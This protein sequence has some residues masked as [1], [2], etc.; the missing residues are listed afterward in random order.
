MS[1]PQQFF[2]RLQNGIVGGFAPPTPNEV[3]TLTRSS[4]DPSNVLV[5][6]LSRPSGQPDLVDHGPKSLSVSE[7]SAL[8]AD[9]PKNVDSRIAELEE[10]LKNLPT[11]S[12]P[13][14]EDI[15]GLNIGIMYGSDR[16][17]WANGGPQGC[18]GGKS[19]VQATAQ[20]KKQ[21]ERAVEI[22]KGLSGGN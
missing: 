10:I 5:Q 6:A 20:E 3:V 18:G 9:D 19:T 14:S 11:E 13:G 7:F 4:D 16:L 17:E 8:S 1:A 21:F 15:Y 12:P 22:I 2:V